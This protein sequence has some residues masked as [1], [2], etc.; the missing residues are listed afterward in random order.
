ML[1]VWNQRGVMTLDVCIH[2]TGREFA[3]INLNRTSL[4]TLLKGKEDIQD[5]YEFEASLGNIVKPP[6]NYLGVVVYT[7]NPSYLGGRGVVAHAC[8][9]STLGGRGRR[10]TGDQ[11]FE[12][13]LANM[14]KPHLY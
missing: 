12:T 1:N 10:I 11:E 5:A 7:C 9:S 4:E 8:N 6:C 14:V 3:K 2:F 13:N